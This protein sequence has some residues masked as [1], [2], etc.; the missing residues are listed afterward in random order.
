MQPFIVGLYLLS[1]SDYYDEKPKRQLSE[2]ENGDCVVRICLLH[3]NFS[4]KSVNSQSP[5]AP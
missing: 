4:K 5:I 3:S 1:K 2:K